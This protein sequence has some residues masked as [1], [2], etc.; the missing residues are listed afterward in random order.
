MKHVWE[1]APF[2]GSFLKRRKED[3]EKILETNSERYMFITDTFCRL[4]IF[5]CADTDGWKSSAEYEVA[6]S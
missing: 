1:A 2:W 5:L 3:D 6:S 4:Y